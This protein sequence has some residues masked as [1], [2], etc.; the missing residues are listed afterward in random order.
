[1]KMPIKNDAIVKVTKMNNFTEI[2]FSELKGKSGPV[3]RVDKDHYANRETGEVY[4][5]EP[6]KKGKSRA[7]NKKS[8]HNTRKKDKEIIFSNFNCS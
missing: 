5:S 8:L 4:E 1:M 2:M 7:S 6:N 3:S